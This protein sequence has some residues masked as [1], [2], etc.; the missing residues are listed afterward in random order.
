MARIRSL[1]LRVFPGAKSTAWAITWRTQSREAHT[2]R[3]LYWGTLPG[4]VEVM[5]PETVVRLLRAI[6]ESIAEG[7]VV[8][9]TRAAGREPR[10]AVGG[11]PD[12]GQG[13]PGIDPDE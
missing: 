1:G 4:T 11:G 8:A 9:S 13:L 3:R 6:T 12:A 5:D 7:R 10:G 2:D